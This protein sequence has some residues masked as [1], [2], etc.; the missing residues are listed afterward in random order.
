MKDILITN[1]AVPEAISF[2]KLGG[3][4]PATFL[5]FMFFAT[6]S[7]KFSKEAVFYIVLTPFLVFF[8]LFIVYYRIFKIDSLYLN[9]PQSLIDSNPF[10]AAVYAWPCSVFYIL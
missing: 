4:L 9:M 8:T 2:L 1:Q 5:F 6:I 3:V 10:M 7:Q